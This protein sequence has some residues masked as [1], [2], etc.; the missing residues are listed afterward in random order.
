MGSSGKALQIIV[1]I[2]ATVAAETMVANPG[3]PNK[4]GDVEIPFPT[5]L[6]EKCFLDHDQNFNITC[7]DSG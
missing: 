5:T 7:D 1:I 6:T 3:C 2:F 4:C